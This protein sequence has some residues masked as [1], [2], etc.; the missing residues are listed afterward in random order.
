MATAVASGVA[1]RRHLNQLFTLRSQRLARGDQKLDARAGGQ[2]LLDE[3]GGA[4]DSLKV[5]EHQEHLTVSKHS[6]Q[7]V[8]DWHL[9]RP[10]YVAPS[11]WRWLFKRRFYA[12]RGWTAE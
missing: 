4:E 12:A 5:V 11:T 6:L 1:K 9:R 3:R 10:A 7:R 8:P 2:H